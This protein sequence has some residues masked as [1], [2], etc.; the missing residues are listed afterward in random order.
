MGGHPRKFLSF[1]PT[2]SL[3][4]PPLPFRLSIS[5]RETFFFSWRFT[6]NR[7][8]SPVISK[9][10]RKKKKKELLGVRVKAERWASIP[11]LYPQTLLSMQQYMR[12]PP[13]PSRPLRSRDRWIQAPGASTRDPWVLGR[14]SPNLCTYNLL[15]ISWGIRSIS[16]ID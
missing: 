14:L 12:R 4:K 11:G 10:R 15:F 8:L 16:E 13:Y 3:C 2:S 9:E 5:A 6:L 7:V 1:R